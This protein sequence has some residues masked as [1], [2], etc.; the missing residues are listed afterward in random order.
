MP[1]IVGL[2]QGLPQRKAKEVE[3]LLTRYF[4][5]EFPE[6]AKLVTNK[7]PQQ[8]LRTISISAQGA[9]EMQ[10]RELRSYLKADSTEVNE[11][12]ELL[13]SGWIR[14]SGC[15]NANQLVHVTGYGDYQ[16][17]SITCPGGLFVA[18][19]PEVLVAEKEPD[20]FGA[21]QT[22]PEEDELADAFEGLK[23]VMTDHDAVADEDSSDDDLPEEVLGNVTQIEIE[24][25]KEE[26]FPDEVDVPTDQPAKVRFRRYRGLKSFRSST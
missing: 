11:A 10:W 26:D 16:L 24:P 22:W 15:F 3:A 14:G 1:Q 21:E 13:V 7:D 8:V 5:S 25:R 23:V 2:I 12:G 19:S 9:E 20:P 4:H 17:A 6:H 18:D